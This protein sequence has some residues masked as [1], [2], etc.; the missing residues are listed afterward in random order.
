MRLL[1]GLLQPL[2]VEL[3]PL[4]EVY[5]LFTCVAKAGLFVHFKPG[6]AHELTL[7]LV[8]LSQ[9]APELIPVP[10]GLLH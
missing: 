9:S 2:I 6:K 7:S 1:D 8:V 10:L 5:S 3:H 4:E